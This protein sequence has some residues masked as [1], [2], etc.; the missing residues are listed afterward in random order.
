MTASLPCLLDNF[1][2]VGML[3]SLKQKNKAVVGGKYIV[4]I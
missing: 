2:W 1:D 4:Q 3:F